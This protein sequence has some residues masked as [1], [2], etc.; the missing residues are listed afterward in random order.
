MLTEELTWRGRRVRWG[1]QGSG[2]AVVFCHGTPWSSALWAPF[3]AALSCE[4]TTYLWD[5]PGYGQSSKEPEHSVA[6]DLQGELLHDLLEYWD[7]SGAH[8]VAHDFGGAVSLR[9]R[10]L[11]GSQ[12][13]SLTLV[14]VVALAPWGSDFFRLVRD[15][16]QVFAQLP[17]AM[18]EGA[19]RA[20]IAGA[21]ETGLTPGQADMLVTPWL[22]ATGQAAFYRQ[23]EQADQCYTDAVEPLYPSLDVPVLVVWGRE[24]RWI[25]VDRAERLALAIPAARLC[26]IE[27]A[28]HL[29]Q[30]DQPIQLA[31][32]LHRWLSAQSTRSS[33]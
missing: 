30:L 24:D 23:I 9:A 15:N 33:S 3:A 31:T 28:G 16:A 25:P 2:P 5:M 10:L 29:V 4:F 27:H 26:L 22:G 8:L 19:L 14:D 1:R 32:E 12:F 17:G 13:T 6:L 20:Y 11:H 21:S 7:L 18:H